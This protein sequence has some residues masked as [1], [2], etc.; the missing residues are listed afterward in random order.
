MKNGVLAI[1][2]LSIGITST[3]QA[4]QDVCV[5][6]LLGKAGESY[7]MMEEWR[8][9]AKGWNTDIQLIA[10]QN[11]ERAD[12]DFKSGKCDAVY[13]TTM[14][15]RTYNKFAG[16]VDALG[17]VPSNAIAQKAIIYVLDKRNIKRL[18]LVFY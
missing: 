7:K 12:Q 11:E 18:N 14:R 13:M 6:D 10:Y 15:S 3:A 16:S 1:V 8:L 9:A 2:L 4:K 5:F 17:G